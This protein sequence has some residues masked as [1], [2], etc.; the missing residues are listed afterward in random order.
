MGFVGVSTS[1]SSIMQ[2]FPLWADILGLPT[3]TL[4]GHDLP[5]DAS[6]EDYLSLVSEIKDDPQKITF[7]V[8]ENAKPGS[9]ILLHVMYESRRPS[10]QAPSL[11]PQYWTISKDKNISA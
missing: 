6:T 7:D 3:R 10:M 8:L 2:V 9:I 11:N 4:R 5:L 1:S